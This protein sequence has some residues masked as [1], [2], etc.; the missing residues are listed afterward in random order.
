MSFDDLYKA[1]YEGRAFPEPIQ[2][3]PH[4]PQF[5][6]I[7][8]NEISDAYRQRFGNQVQNFERKYMAIL[9]IHADAN[10]QMHYTSF[11]IPK[12]SGG[13]RTINAPHEVTKQAMSSMLEDLQRYAIYEHNAAYAFV[14]NRCTRDAIAVHQKTGNEWFMKLD[15]HDF[16]GSCNPAFIEQQLRKLPFFALMDIR[17][18]RNFIHFAC[19]GDGLP[20]GSP[21][22]PWITNQIMV[23]YDYYIN[24]EAH[25]HNLTYTRYADDM[26]FSGNS[27]NAVRHAEGIVKAYLANTPL[28]IN[29]DKTRVSSIYGQNWNLGIM[30]NKDHNITIGYK[31]KE[32]LRAMLHH[33]AMNKTEWHYQ[34]CTELLGLIQYFHTI[35]P[36]YIDGLLTKA[37]QKYS[38]DIQS[39]I[40]TI[41]KQGA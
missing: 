16:F 27:K 33:F 30:L 25:I 21:L 1:F 17:N 38:M 26:L 14:Q 41:I 15:L 9:Q 40:I 23:E 11:K 37:N 12:H 4:K 19:L 20:Q 3:T 22:S 8:V 7:E 31:K 34:E 39:E 6:T 5:R 35:E 32:R 29:G 13:M 18:L 36:D 24:K 10:M 2:A 28:T